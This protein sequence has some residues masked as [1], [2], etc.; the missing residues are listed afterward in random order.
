MV[1]TTFCPLRPLYKTLNHDRHQPTQ[2]KK[3]VKIQNHF[4]SSPLYFDIFFLSESLCTSS[5]HQQ[6]II[7]HSDIHHSREPGESDC[8]ICFLCFSISPTNVCVM[9]HVFCV[10]RLV[11]VASSSHFCCVSF[12]RRKERKGKERKGKERHEV[13]G[14]CLFLDLVYGICPCH[15]PFNG[16]TTEAGRSTP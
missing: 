6:S 4:S 3:K 13:L 5:H 12:Q 8:V 7:R 2:D 14:C 10:L 11:L 15:G 16:L 1:E 9:S